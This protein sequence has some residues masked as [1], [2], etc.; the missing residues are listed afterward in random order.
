MFFGDVP[1]DLDYLF[2]IEYLNNRSIK[3]KNCTHLYEY[4]DD[5][6][7]YISRI[8]K[9]DIK[10]IGT[11]EAYQYTHNLLRE[12]PDI[13]AKYEEITEYEDIFDGENL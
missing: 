2:K 10:I 9:I 1:F 4:E 7:Y 13:L 12:Y 6:M 5:I 3:L 8:E 11:V